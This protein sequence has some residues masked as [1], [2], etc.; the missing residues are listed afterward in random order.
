MYVK[1]Q[2]VVVSGL[3]TNKYILVA[4]VNLSV[5]DHSKPKNKDLQMHQKWLMQLDITMTHYI[6]EVDTLHL[7]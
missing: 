1:I 4:R 3:C 5:K 7:L 6:P 2:F